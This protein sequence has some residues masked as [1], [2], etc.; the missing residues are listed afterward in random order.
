MGNGGMPTLMEKEIKDKI[1]FLT[2]S[3]FSS[4]Q[5]ENFTNLWSWRHW[6]FTIDCLGTLAD[7]NM[8]FC[9]TEKD[10]L[11]NQERLLRCMDHPQAVSY[12]TRFKVRGSW[13]K[14]GKSGELKK[15]KCQYLGPKPRDFD[16]I[17]L[18]NKI[19]FIYLFFKLL[20]RW[21]S[22]AANVENHCLRLWCTNL[23][24]IVVWLFFFF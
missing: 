8:H 15:K 11:Y 6:I 24:I 16:L 17:D 22:C 18:G 19:L 21:L 1:Q 7:R 5:P 9:S 14:S 3:Y 20:P 10:V 23:V 2:F 4:G 13:M 12:Q